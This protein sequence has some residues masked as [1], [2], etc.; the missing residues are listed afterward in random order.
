MVAPGQEPI[1]HD[2]VGVRKQLEEAK[3]LGAS[4]VAR[5]NDTRLD[6]AIHEEV[7]NREAVF[8]LERER[9]PVRVLLVGG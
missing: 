3:V 6:V 4:N 5:K 8:S 2:E 7:H 1:T 9:E